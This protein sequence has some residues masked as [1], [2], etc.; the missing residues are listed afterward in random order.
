VFG[1]LL[2]VLFGMPMA[3]FLAYIVADLFAVGLLTV[4]A[5]GIATA[6]LVVGIAGSAVVAAL[7]IEAIKT[8]RRHPR[9]QQRQREG[10]GGQR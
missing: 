3:L 6:F 5:V 9:Q 2:G 10:K 1:A 4:T 8:E 7:A